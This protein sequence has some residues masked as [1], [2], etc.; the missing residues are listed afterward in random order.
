MT[1]GDDLP[2]RVLETLRSRGIDPAAVGLNREV[3]ELLAARAQRTGRPY[4]LDDRE[5]TLAL[6]IWFEAARWGPP[7]E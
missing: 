5:R 3:L 1:H 4:P 7:P 6:R 2:E